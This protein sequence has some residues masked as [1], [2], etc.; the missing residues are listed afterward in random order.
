MSMAEWYRIE[1]H[2]VDVRQMQHKDTYLK[3]T[4]RDTMLEYFSDKFPDDKDVFED[5]PDLALAKMYQLHKMTLGFD[6]VGHLKAPVEVE[7]LQDKDGNDVLD[8]M[9]NVVYVHKKNITHLIE[10]KINSLQ[11]VAIDEKNSAEV[12]DGVSSEADVST[13][14][15]AL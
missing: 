4:D 1:G 13:V 14:N 2:E 11:G 6:V 3:F 8:N 9:G 15:Q 10:E 7:A 5:L 12:S